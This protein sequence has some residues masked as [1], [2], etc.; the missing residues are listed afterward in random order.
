MSEISLI[1]NIKTGLFFSACVIATLALLS[2][3]GSLSG[4]L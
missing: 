3:Y 2:F 4:E 1:E